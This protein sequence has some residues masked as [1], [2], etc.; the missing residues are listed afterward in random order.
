MQR[1]RAVYRVR[2][3]RDEQAGETLDLSDRVLSFDFEDNE[4]KADKLTL[5]VDN[6]D[7]RNFDDPVWRKGVVLEVSWGYPG[8]MSPARHC[9]IVKVKGSLEL[10]IEA[11]GLAMALH[12]AKK[13]RVFKN[14]TLQ[15]M[16]DQIQGEY[17][18][19]LKYEDKVKTGVVPATLADN[20]LIQ[21]TV[22]AC[23]TDAEFLAKQARKFGLIFHVDGHGK[24][25][26][27]ERNLKQPPVKTLVWR[28]GVGDWEDFDIENDITARVGA[29]TLK[30]VDTK[31]KAEVE[32]RADNESTKRD[33]LMA[34]VE[35]VD[36]RTDSTNK[37]MRLVAAEDSAHVAGQ[38]SAEV[39]ARAEAKFKDSQLG[40]IKLTG[41]MV[42]DPK[43]VARCV[44]DLKGLGKRVSGRYYTK[45]VT[46]SIG[47][48][49][50]YHTHF[51]ARGDGHGGYSSPTTQNTPSKASPNKAQ[52]TD[53]PGAPQIETVE[54][55]DVR[56]KET[57]TTYRKRGAE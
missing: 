38:S 2:A 46:H 27:R 14:M 55:V 17:A 24:I 12:K 1:D 28:G 23:Q 52:A 7:L 8:E 31:T 19:I 56:T 4:S 42:G 41:T 5:R 29:V 16:A 54:V 6:S 30:S 3:F 45:Q 20:L 33:G 36:V 49:G 32:H 40:T 18:A 43:V 11:H 13:C 53:A 9:K 26:F 34:V 37:Q 47:N 50:L 57:H 21:H 51:K 35:V 25:Q 22:Q 48:E 10:S 39:K 44:L 15:Q